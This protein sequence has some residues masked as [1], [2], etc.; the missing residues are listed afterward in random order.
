M[1]RRSLSRP[2]ILAAAAAS[3]T[4]VVGMMIAGTS[5]AAAGASVEPTLALVTGSAVPFVS[6]AQVI[7]DAAASQQLSIEVW[8]K[9]RSAAAQ[10]F[11]DAVS[12]PGSPLSGHYLRPDGYTSRFGPTPAEESAVVSWLRSAGFTGVK[13]DAQRSYVR[14]TATTARIDAAF[15]VR[16]KLYRS[17]ATATAGPYTL[18]ANDYAKANDMAVPSGQRYTEL[19]LGQGSA[20]GDPSTGRSK[21][22]SRPPTTWPPGQASSSSAVTLATTVT[23]GWRGSSTPTW[24]SSMAPATVRLPRW[25]PTPGRA[26]VNH[27]PPR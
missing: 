2:R 16:L 18:R 1:I 9:P 4:A 19:S 14:A 22:T 25:P 3:A 17:S 24:R 7:G 11:A 27:R 10:S 21:S 23:T 6:H 13:A 26:G 8:L 15:R 5:G 12:T 20:C